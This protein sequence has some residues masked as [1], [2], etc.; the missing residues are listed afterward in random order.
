MDKKT[1]IDKLIN[2][3]KNKENFFECA[4]VSFVLL[5]SINKPLILRFLRIYL[6]KKGDKSN[7]VTWDYK[8]ACL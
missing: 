8:E 5:K 7:D 6:V 2:S 4:R 3:I 1:E